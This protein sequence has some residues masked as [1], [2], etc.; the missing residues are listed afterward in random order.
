MQ[1]IRRK[2]PWEEEETHGGSVGQT[3]IMQ[4]IICFL[5]IGGMFFISRTNVNANFLSRINQEINKQMDMNAWY[6]E[7][8]EIKSTVM[9]YVNYK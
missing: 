9:D 7:A 3:L 6:Q 2:K 8:K 4:S 5:I 1:D